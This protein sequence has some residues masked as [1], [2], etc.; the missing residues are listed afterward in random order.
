MSYS[1]KWHILL[2]MI[3][4]LSFTILMSILLI[5]IGFIARYE[6][7]EGFA[8]ENNSINHVQYFSCKKSTNSVCDRASNNHTGYFYPGA[9]KKI[10]QVTREPTF[11]EGARNKALEMRANNFESI[12]MHDIPALNSFN[13]SVSLWIKVPTDTPPYGHI[14]SHVD[15][16]GT[17]GW[18]LDMLS[19]STGSKYVRLRVTNTEG[20]I[21]T[22]KEIPVETGKFIHIS[23]TFNGS[24]LSVYKN[25]NVIGTTAYNGSYWPYSLVPLSIGAASYGSAQLGWSGSISDLI[26]FNTTLSAEDIKVLSLAK[27]IN[28]FPV[29]KWSFDGSLSDSSPNHNDGTLVTLVS[30]MT[31]SPDGGL[32]FAKKN[33][34]QIMY[35]KGNQTAPRVFVTVPDLY[36]NWEQ[37]LLGITIDPNYSQNKFIYAYYTAIDKES[38]QPFNRVVRYTDENGVASGMKILLDRI[39]ASLGYH[40]GGALA[41]GPDDKLYIT[42]GDATEHI[43]AQDPSI[44]IGKILRINRDGTIPLDNPFP[45]SP[46]YTLGHRNM[47]G[48]AFDIKNKIGIVTENG[49]IYYDEIN[50]VKKG[51]NYGFPTLQEPNI[52]PMLSNDSSIKPIRSYKFT[53]GPTQAIYYDGSKIPELRNKFLFGTF[54]GNIYAIGISK[55]SNQVNQ[56]DLINPRIFPFDPIIGIAKSPDGQIFFGGYG[57]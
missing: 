18:Y 54:T 55:I 43:F 11:V 48:I 17:S 22:S 10:L 34:G 1:G 23:G 32:F 25:G 37:G 41:F 31:F 7:S 57:I 4:K 30:S 20:I 44:L 29:G 24:I 26:L 15:R 35:L 9:V 16:Q 3:K 49:D 12:L 28:D 46:V 6:M 8:A 33:T 52:D 42:V 51:G 13:F 5:M 53:I 14:I 45:N 2:E 36:V 39:P 38:L 19:N 56:E 27:A 40:S 50:L 47:Y 21:S